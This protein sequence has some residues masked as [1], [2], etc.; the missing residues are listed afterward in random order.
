[1]FDSLQHKGR[2]KKLIDSLRHKYSFDTRVLDAMEK[3]PRHMFIDEELDAMAYLDKPLPIA[4]KQT[5]SQPFT[6][7]M[8]THLLG[9]NKFDKVLEIGTGCAYQ[10]AV[11]AEMG[12]RVYSIER[13]K[14]LYI[15]AQ[16]NLA[17]LD[18][19]SPLIF[20]GDGFA[21]LPKFAP[22]NGIL[23]TCG[24]PEIPR[25]LLKQMA[26]GGKM[27]IPV[28]DV[29]QKMVVVERF[30]EDDYK[31]TEHGDYNFVPM[32]KGTEQ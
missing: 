17:R 32:L 24:A 23:V 9:L 2:R 25:E 14:P 18:Y 3:V 28:G 7:A 6:V 20:Y 8:Q 15:V 27:V 5:I 26:I 31:I 11:L 21:G 12:F 10:T 1:M 30:S 16:Q 4:A 19:H 22:F 29:S 13:Q